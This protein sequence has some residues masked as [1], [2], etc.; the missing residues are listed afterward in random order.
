VIVRKTTAGR[1]LRMIV[2]FPGWAI[3][4]ATAEQEIG[5]VVDPLRHELF[6]FVMINFEGLVL[7]QTVRAE[8][9]KEV[10]KEPAL[11]LLVGCPRRKRWRWT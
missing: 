3:T 4:A 7:D 5:R 8:M 6:G 11:I 9:L 2:P 10:V 1:I